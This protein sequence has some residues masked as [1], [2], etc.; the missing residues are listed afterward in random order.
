MIG[1]YD[2]GISQHSSSPKQHKRTMRWSPDRDKGQWSSR[3]RR[4]SAARTRSILWSSTFKTSSAACTTPSTIRQ[5]VPGEAYN[6]SPMRFLDFDQRL[7]AL[8]ARP[9]HR[10]RI[11]RVWLKG[12]ALDTGTRRRSSENFLPLA[13][14]DAIPALTTE[15]NGLARVRSQHAS[16]DGS[17]LLVELADG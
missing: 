13:L 11:M 3:Y 2:R 17:R 16:N 5:L 9:V 6:P 10:G 12:Q 8:D 14:R 4:Q 7:G 15:L 1:F